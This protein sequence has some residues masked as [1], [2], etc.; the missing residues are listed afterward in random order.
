MGFPHKSLGGALGFL[1]ISSALCDNIILIQR[2]TFEMEMAYMDNLCGG[3]GRM[4]LEKVLSPAELKDKCAL[5]ARVTL[6]PGAAEGIV[7]V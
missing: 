1:A 6:P 4:T 5:Y 3:S 7:C 2:K